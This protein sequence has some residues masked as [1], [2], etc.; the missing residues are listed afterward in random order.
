[1]SNRVETISLTRDSLTDSIE[2]RNSREIEMDHQKRD[3]TSSELTY[4]SISAQLKLVTESILKRVERLC[5]LITEKNDI[6][7][8]ANSEV[9][10][11]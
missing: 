4:Q 2:V 7:S 6:Y 9:I 8:A 5:A 3:F 11:S 10:A 1:M